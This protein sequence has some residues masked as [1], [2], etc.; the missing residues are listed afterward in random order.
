MLHPAALTQVLGVPQE[1]AEVTWPLVCGA[2]GA[3]HILTNR[4]EVAAAATIR[5]EVGQ[6]F[7]PIG[8]RG[9]DAYFVEHYWTNERVRLRLGNQS[10]EDAV[11]YRGR[12]YI[13]ITGR[14][15]YDRYGRLLGLDLL[16]DPDLAL[17]PETA[18]RILA[19]YFQGRSIHLAAELGNWRTVRKRVNGGFNQWDEFKQAV[20]GLLEV[21]GG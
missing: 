7:M 12:G 19:S 20:D 5:V 15:N 11:R 17:V 1:A 3:E 21:I 4:T 13:Q 9:G 16:G 2:L 6:P 18:A 14:D 10:A 8:E